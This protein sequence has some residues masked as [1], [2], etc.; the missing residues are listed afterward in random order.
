MSF[1]I[2]LPLFEGPFDLLLFFIERDELDIHNIPISKITKDFLEYIRDME[3]LNIEIASDFILVAAKLMKLKSRELLPRFRDELDPEDELDSKEALIAHLLE[4]RK[5]KTVL[6]PLREKEESYLQTL[7]RGTITLDFEGLVKQ[8]DET[9]L[10]L[11]SLSLFKL[12]N[13][14]SSVLSKYESEKDHK[15]ESIIPYA[16]SV[17]SQKNFI[18]DLLLKETEVSFLFMVEKLKE[19]IA[20]IFTFLAILELLQLREI[21]LSMGEGF[22]DFNL[23]K[24]ENAIV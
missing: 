5:L 3:R 19:R 16:Y 12:M 1:E 10:E 22:N 6:D 8:T 24:K 7:A 13:V 17:E 21:Q 15:V 11:Q 9:S 23:L 14:Y 18:L 2:H 20:V 4:Y